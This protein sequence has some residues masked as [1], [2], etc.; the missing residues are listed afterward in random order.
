M[1]TRTKCGVC[2]H[3]RL[4]DAETHLIQ[5]VAQF[6]LV[7]LEPIAS[8]IHGNN[9]HEEIGVRC[10]EREALAA[11]TTVSAVGR[12]NFTCTGPS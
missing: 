3:Q 10:S 5:H 1:Q 12:A 6:S 7:Q 8:L 11:S 2:G 4:G 9:L